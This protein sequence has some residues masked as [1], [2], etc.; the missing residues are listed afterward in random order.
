[1][2]EQYDRLVIDFDGASKNNPR[3]PAGCGWL[4]YERCNY[5]QDDL[6][7]IA[8]GQ[9]YLGDNVSNNQAEYRG[10]DAALEYLID[11]SI[12]CDELYIQGDS[13]IVLKQLEGNYQVRSQNIIP[14][15]NQILDRL[16]SIQ[17]NSITYKHIDR[18]NNYAADQY[19][20]QAIIDECDKTNNYVH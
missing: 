5:C 11:E 10:L 20:N 6:S 17:Y 7:L 19:A 3:G 8:S 15:Y 2:Y 12:S 1:M 4:I 9:R 14:Y 13:E 18:A 16:D